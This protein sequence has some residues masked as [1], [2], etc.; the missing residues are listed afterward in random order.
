MCPN[1]LH[2][3]YLPNQGNCSWKV[4]SLR[5]HRRAFMIWPVPSSFFST[6]CSPSHTLAPNTW[7]HV[8]FLAVVLTQEWHQTPDEGVG[9][10]FGNMQGHTDC[11][12]G[13]WD[14]GYYWHSVHR[15]W[16]PNILQCMGEFH[17]RTWVP[18]NCQEL[19]LWETLISR[20][21]PLVLPGTRSHPCVTASFPWLTPS[22]PS[23][24]SKDTTYCKKDSLPT[25]PIPDLPTPVWIGC[26]S[27][28]LHSIPCWKLLTALCPQALVQHPS[29]SRHPERRCRMTNILLQMNKGHNKMQ[30]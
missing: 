11:V 15:S 24:L 18:S 30:R 17:T 4:N 12:F 22:N 25:P 16:E 10:A 26:H 2:T 13:E 3:V 29:H 7:H 1:P 14:R 9:Y 19:P 8:Y 28:V 20:L 5:W 27:C 6:F 21:M 23:E